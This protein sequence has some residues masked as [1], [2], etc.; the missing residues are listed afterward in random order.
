MPKPYGSEG[1]LSLHSDGG[2]FAKWLRA[3]TKDVDIHL[4]KEPQ[5]RVMLRN[6]DIWLPMVWLGMNVALPVFLGLVANYL[7]DRAKGNL[8][9]ER[10]TAHVEA[11]YRD[12]KAGVY[13]KF[14]FEGDAEQLKAAMKKLDPNEFMN[15]DE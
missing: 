6:N 11:V 5:A 8:K 13:K 10:T 3:T 14:K 12:R 15:G 2:D 1:T 4:P 9:G 7:S